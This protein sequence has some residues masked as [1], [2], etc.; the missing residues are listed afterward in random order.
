MERYI[1][2]FIAFLNEC[3]DILKKH[4][5]Y[6]SRTVYLISISIAPNNT[7]TTGYDKNYDQ[8]QDRCENY[9]IIQ[10]DIVIY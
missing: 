8:T 1:E 6:V 3:A 4:K 5:M 7:T 10:Y 2:G 9:F